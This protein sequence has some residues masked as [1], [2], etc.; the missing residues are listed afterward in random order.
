MGK[1]DFC[2]PKK[3]SDMIRSRVKLHL[4]NRPMDHL[5][6]AIEAAGG[7]TALAAGLGIHKSAVT[8]WEQVPADRVLA[9]VELC[10]WVVTPHQL[11][12]DIYPNPTDGL[13][14]SRILQK[15]TA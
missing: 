12:P 13:P 3:K 15:E 11:R 2:F 10:G 14:L 7:G 4:R 5:Q 1:T 8:H 9:V 6:K